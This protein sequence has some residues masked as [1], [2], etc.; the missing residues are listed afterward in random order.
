ME[1]ISIFEPL[2]PFNLSIRELKA[3]IISALRRSVLRRFRSENT[4][5]YHDACAGGVFGGMGY[6][7]WCFVGGDIICYVLWN[8]GV[9]TLIDIH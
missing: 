6:W 7:G 9:I 3:K 2:E 8:F 4:F 1:T 5:S